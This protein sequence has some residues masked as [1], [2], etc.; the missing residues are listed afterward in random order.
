MRKALAILLAL[1]SLTL[2]ADEI[3][4][5]APVDGFRLG[6]ALDQAATPPALRVLIENKTG[7][8][9]SFLVNYK[10]GTR[11]YPLIAYATSPDGKQQYSLFDS[12]W[13]Q[14]PVAGPPSVS[15]YARLEPGATYE[16]RLVLTDLVLFHPSS[17]SPPPV[18]LATL[19]RQGYSVHATANLGGDPGSGTHWK[20]LSGEF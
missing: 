8:A 5:G 9:Q 18:D 2:A 13:G 4:W 6:V 20:L 16:Y 19:L 15:V 17:T 1:A 7:K 10:T 3:A 11:M 12:V 14:M